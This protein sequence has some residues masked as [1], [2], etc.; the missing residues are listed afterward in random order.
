MYKLLFRFNK[1]AGH[2]TQVVWAQTAEVGCGAVTT[3]S[4]FTDILIE[5]SFF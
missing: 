3:R 5:K 1:G 4:E 2:Y